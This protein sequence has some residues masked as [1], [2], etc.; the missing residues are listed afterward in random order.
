MKQTCS[1][2]GAQYQEMDEL[3]AGLDR[4]QWRL[5]TPFYHWTIF[6]QVAH[7]AFF[8][9][10]SL[11]AIEDPIRFKKQAKGVMEIVRSGDSWP[12]R[13]NPMLGLK[14]PGQL[15]PRWRTVRMR[16]LERLQMMAPRDRLPW[17]GPDM[18]ARSFATARL[19]E[20]WAHAQDIFDTF[21]MKRNNSAR[22]HH[23]AHLGV[24][25]FGWSF[26]VKGMKAPDISPFVKLFGPSGEQWE[27]GK[28]DEWNRVWGSAEEFCLVVT[29]RRN[30][31]DTLLKWQGG[32]AEKWLSIGQAFAGVSQEPPAPGVRKIDD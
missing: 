20:T 12:E 18:S 19:M 21:R 1:D 29:Q 5:E 16:L 11:L 32:H 26:K 23:V 28:P 3:V 8:D 22:L 2:L 25:T 24:T 14:E 4:E 27:W 13:F 17:Y 7:V 10:E 6:D 9:Q 30:L 15:L 31:A